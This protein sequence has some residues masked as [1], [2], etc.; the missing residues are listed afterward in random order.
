[1]IT[2]PLVIETS[3]ILIRQR[4]GVG[5]LTLLLIVFLNISLFNDILL[6]PES[7]YI[8]KED[9]SN[10]L[11]ILLPEK[12]QKDSW[13]SKQLSEN[14]TITFGWT[15]PGHGIWFKKR[16]GWQ[17]QVILSLMELILKIVLLNHS[18]GKLT[19]RPIMF[20]YRTSPKTK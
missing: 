18:I 10:I 8:A 20:C 17:R 3:V 9:N 2:I 6:K 4:Y 19:Q 5:L 12:C 13:L 15:A 11:K 16:I 14:E 7:S 1:M